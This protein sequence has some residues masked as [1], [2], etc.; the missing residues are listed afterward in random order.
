MENFGKVIS[1]I[2]SRHEKNQFILIVKILKHLMKPCF[3]FQNKSQNNKPVYFRM[4][5]F[6]PKVNYINMISK[7][8]VIC[9]KSIPF[10]NNNQ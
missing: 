6:T 10:T 3:K 7:R 2:N 9:R 8:N 1:L 4:P 5:L